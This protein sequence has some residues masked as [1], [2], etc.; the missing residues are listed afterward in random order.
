MAKIFRPKNFAVQKHLTTAFSLYSNVVS[1]VKIYLRTCST[2]WRALG[3]LP[4]SSQHPSCST[5]SGSKVPCEFTCPG[6]GIV[7]NLRNILI[8]K[9]IWI[10]TLIG[11]LNILSNVE[12]ITWA[13]RLSTLYWYCPQ[14]TY[15]ASYFPK[16]GVS[17]SNGCSISVLSS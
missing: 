3:G 16:P 11:I 5:G 15:A 7:S 17:S 6:V 8:I 2:S 4:A 1:S 14:I 9:D 10:Y 12:I 13:T